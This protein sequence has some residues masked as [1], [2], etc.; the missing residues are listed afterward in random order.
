MGAHRTE[1]DAAAREFIAGQRLFFVATAPLSG[2]GHINLSPK[3]LDTFRVLGP[4]RVGYL[5]FTGSGVETIAHVRENGRLTIMFCAFAGPP[6]ILRLHGRGRAVEPQEA[7]FAELLR[8]FGTT[9]GQAERDGI[10]AVV[11]LDVARVAD[12]CGYGVPRY[13]YV[14]ERD[15]IAAWAARKGVEGLAEYRK[16]KNARS[17]DGL[18]GLRG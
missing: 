3:G 18:E 2:D 16:L 17:L 6:N 10:R 11:V 9:P 5:D 8:V 12:S 15:Q 4:K 7:E 13:E 1:I 14:G